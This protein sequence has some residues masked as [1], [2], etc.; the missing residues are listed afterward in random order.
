[1]TMWDFWHQ[2][3]FLAFLAIYFIAMGINTIA[4]YI[5]IMIC[6]WPEGQEF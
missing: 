3:W 4:K 5:T 2:H 1:M 6:G